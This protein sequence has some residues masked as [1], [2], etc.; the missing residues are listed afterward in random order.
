MSENRQITNANRGTPIP[1][2]A[3]DP[4]SCYRALLARDVRFDGRISVAVTSTGIYCRPVCP[5]PPAKFTNCRFFPPAAAAQQAGFR[6]CR[7]RPETTCDLGWWR[8]TSNT[9][10]RA[11]SM[12]ADGAL[13][14]GDRHIDTLAKRLGPGERQLRRLFQQ[15]VGPSP[16]S[17]AR[18]RRILFAEQL[19]HET[20]LSMTEVALAAGFGSIRQFHETFLA[21]FRRPPGAMRRVAGPDPD[22]SVGGVQVR[23]RYRPPCDWNSVLGPLRARAIPGLRVVG[24]WSGFETAVRAV[25]GQQVTSEA[26]RRL[27]RPPVAL[28]SEEPAVNADPAV[29]SR[30]FPLPARVAHGDGGCCPLFPGA[31]SGHYRCGRAEQKHPQTRRRGGRSGVNNRR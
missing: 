15:H 20:S 11:L 1:M 13:D 10:S 25:L 24:G 6:P 19:L 7:R 2:N 26:G 28:C 31:G 5:A 29:L 14:G 16:C 30:P 8:G 22:S 12:I 9:V 18:T 4:H 23:L 17:V 3:L 21:L 27:T